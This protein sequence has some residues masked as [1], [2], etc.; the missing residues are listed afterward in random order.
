MRYVAYIVAQIVW[1]LP[2]TLVGAV[3][4]LA[5]C[6]RPHFF[7][8]GAIVT[9]WRLWGK[10]LS[11]GPFVFLCRLGP[12]A[13]P[14]QVDE[15]LLVHEYGHTVQSLIFGPLYLPVMGLPSLVWATAPALKRRRHDNQASY[16][17]FYPER[18][19]N[20]LGERVLKKS[21]TGQA[22]ID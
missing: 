9:V 20:W 13:P 18:L 10:G 12:A 11:L 16:Y 4:F 8:H 5:C 19:A 1:G 15:Q 21:S 3:V 7:Y 14:T 22:V 2:Q 6:R 17:A